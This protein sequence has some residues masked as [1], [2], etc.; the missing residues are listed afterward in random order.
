M[1]RVFSGDYGS[2]DMAG[3]AAQLNYVAGFTYNASFKEGDK[4]ALGEYQ[5]DEW[6]E[7]L[8]W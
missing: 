5:D 4:G 8:T 2:D 1:D 3:Q 6:F 7:I